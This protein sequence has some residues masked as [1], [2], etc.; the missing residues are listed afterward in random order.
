MSTFKLFFDTF[1]S[2][3]K[4]EVIIIYLLIEN[5]VVFSMTF[6]LQEKD[7]IFP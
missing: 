2:F 5:I 7:F 4:R 3:L 6:W 1:V